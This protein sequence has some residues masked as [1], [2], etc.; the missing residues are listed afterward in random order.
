MVG[1][2][3][4]YLLYGLKYDTLYEIR[5]VT[6]ADGYSAVSNSMFVRTGL[7]SK[8]LRESGREKNEKGRLNRLC[9]LQA[10]QLRLM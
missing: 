5:V 1:S 7:I 4:Q 3:L 9:S 8:G 2:V 10:Y 6:V